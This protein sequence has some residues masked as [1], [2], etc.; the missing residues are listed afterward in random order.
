MTVEM[1]QQQLD[2]VLSDIEIVAAKTGMLYSEEIIQTVANTVKDTSIQLVVDP[3]MVATSGSV[4]LKNEA[5][6]SLTR[7]II[8]L[9]TI[10]T[11][12]LP[13]ALVL[14][15]RDKIHDLSQMKQ[16]C[17]DLSKMGPQY[18]LLKGGHCPFVGDRVLEIEEALVSKE[19][20]KIV[21]IVYCT[22]TKEMHLYW[23]PFVKT[24]NTHGTGCTL[25]AAITSYL[26]LGKSPLKAIELAMDYVQ[27]AIADGFPIGSGAGP[28]NHFHNISTSVIPSPSLSDPYPFVRYLKSKCEHSWHE[29]THHPFVQGIQDGTLPRECFQHYIIQDYFFLVQYARVHGLGAYKAETMEDSSYFAKVV[30]SI[31]HEA[32]KHLNLCQEWGVPKE[33]VLKTKESNQTTAYT[34]YV[35]DKG[36]SGSLVDLRVAVAPCLI[37]YGE[38]GARLLNDP[39]TKTDNPYYPWIQTYG[40]P[41]FHQA[42]TLGME[43][44]EREARSL[45]F[46]SKRMEQLSQIFAEATD[47][48]IDFW[49]MGLDRS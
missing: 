29:Y 35:L 37:G 11:P 42:V 49:Q 8:P 45:R 4:L 36:L 25:S 47:L 14:L 20:V 39:K 43:H 3:V 17:I 40:S 27:G 26:G 21:D 34:R 44:L 41:E 30:L 28:L 9:S 16:I 24:R 19:D 12:N 23:K 5:I 22:V 18:V 15:K 31:E 13:E 6:E 7:N 32:T 33:Q 48:E 10:I 1:V 46:N 38:I 2:S